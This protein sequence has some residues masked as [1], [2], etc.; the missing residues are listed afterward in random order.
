M[1]KT[2]NEIFNNMKEKIEQL[3]ISPVFFVGSGLSRRYFNAPDWEGLLREVRD[4]WDRSFDYYLQGFKAGNKYELEKLAEKLCDMYYEKLTDE[5]LEPN[6]DKIYYFKKRVTEIINE[7]FYNSIDSFDDN[8]EIESF[9]KTSPS[10]VITTNYDLFLENM[11]PDYDVYIGQQSLLSTNLGAVG[12]IYKIHGCVSDVNSIVITEADYKNFEQRELYLNAKL[13]TLFL[14][15][16]IIFLGYSLSDRNVLSTLTSIIKMLPQEKVNELSNRI[17]FVRRNECQEDY[18]KTERINLGEGLFIDVETFYLNDFSNLYNIL[19]TN[20]IQK[21]PMKFLKYLKA[22]AY[23]VTSS[24]VYNPK[25]LNVNLTDIHKIDDFENIN[26]IIGLSFSTENKNT[27]DIFTKRDI[28]EAILQQEE[29]EYSESAIKFLLHNYNTFL[30]IHFFAQ[31]FENG[32]IE[33]VID[34]AEVSELARE[35]VRNRLYN[36]QNYKVNIGKN[37][38][39]SFNTQDILDIELQKECLHE[40]IDKYCM[41]GEILI[42]SYNTVMKYFLLELIKNRLDELSQNEEILTTYRAFILQCLTHLEEEDIQNNITGIIILL[43]KLDNQT[44]EADY[45]KVICYIDQTLYFQ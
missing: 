45:R 5:Q 23:K 4:T 20:K 15:Y 25:L 31:G 22:N 10:A 34:S 21:L 36:K 26:N 35:T 29:C 1:L 14:E 9:K 24:Q 12:E 44:Y 39:Y 33:E 3:A 2:E 13:L 6:K 40:F 16:P 28:I 18:V 41:E 11:F 27:K 7:Y 30:P 19:S 37:N 42:S 17:W 38:N 8:H 43:K 32:K